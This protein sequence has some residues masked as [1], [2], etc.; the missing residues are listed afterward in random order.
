MTVCCAPDAEVALGIPVHGATGPSREEIGLTSRLSPAGL[1]HV[2]LSVPGV[3]CSDCIRNVERALGALAGV[4]RARVNLSTKRVGV[5]WRADAAVP[6]LTETLNELGYEAHLFEAGDEERDDTMAELVRGLAVAGFAAGNIMLLSVSVWSGADAATRDMFHWLSALI[7]LPALAFAG[8]IFFRSAWGAVRNGR[9]NMDVPI[10]IGILLA[11]G[12]SLYETATSGP[13]AYF[14]AAASLL[15]FLLIGRT[16]DHMMRERARVAVKGLARLAARGA[17]VIDEDG[18][19]NYRPVSEIVPGVRLQLAAG[20]RVPVDA[21]VV[22]GRSELDCAIVSGESAPQAVAP[23]DT[24]R[25]GTLNLTGALEIEAT[26]AAA[27]SFLAEMVRLMEAAESG[28]G[29]YRRIA[30][31]ASTLYAPVVHLTAFLAFVA[32]LF[33]DGDFHHAITIAIAVLIIT[34]PCALGLA[35][36]IVQVAAARKLFENGIMVKDGSALERLAEIDRVAFDKTGTLTMGQPLLLTADN[37]N[38]EEL[39]IAAALGARSRHPLSQALYRAGIRWMATAPRFDGVTELPGF[40]MESQANGDHY[41]LGRAAW[42]LAE[43]SATTGTVLS[44][45]GKLLAAFSFEDSLRID[46]FEAVHRLQAAGVGTEMVSGDRADA[47][48]NIA[49]SL[50]IGLAT[51]GMLPED[52]VARLQTLK[53]AGHRVLMVGDGL[54][55]APA[56]AAAHVSMAPATAADIGR[57]AADFV[58]LRDSLL[59][60]PLARDVAIRSNRLIRQ[61]LGLAIVYNLIAVPIA[62]FGYVTPLVAALAMSLSSVIVIANGLRLGAGGTARIAKASD[63]PTGNGADSLTGNGTLLG[64]PV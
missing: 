14:D 13:H 51:P 34:C 38:P 19:R 43:G 21:V 8:R 31:R 10:S 9:T 20:E 48:E 37:V 56:L 64:A 25:A 33:I 5:D 62:L 59:A 42:A 50:D 46:A 53:A 30:D 11:F 29:G 6:A 16:L 35:V 32:W 1:R 26:A 57:S 12:L 47:V 58:F 36:P 39:G 44:R 17:T 24:I 54:N 60:V 7:A 41:R 40:G 61:N 45:N 22:A 49:K 52:K 2:D 63:S 18:S 23:G 27:D 15:F 28:R 55:D 4:E 3:H